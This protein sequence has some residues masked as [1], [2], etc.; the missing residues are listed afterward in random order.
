MTISIARGTAANDSSPRR[1]N[2]Q[3]IQV[4]LNLAHGRGD[5]VAQA[6]ATSKRLRRHAGDQFAGLIDHGVEFDIRPDIEFPEP[7]EEVREIGD[8]RIAEDLGFGLRTSD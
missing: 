8:D 7:L 2:D 5:L 6:G 1:G 4:G 3:T